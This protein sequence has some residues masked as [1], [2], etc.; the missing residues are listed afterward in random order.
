MKKYLLLIGIFLG[1]C[2]VQANIDVDYNNGIYHAV[3]SGEKV[4]KRLEFV[5]STNLI[6]NKEAHNKA[7]SLFTINTVFKSFILT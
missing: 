4:Q 3:L 7:D 5:S 1:V 2:S 6:T